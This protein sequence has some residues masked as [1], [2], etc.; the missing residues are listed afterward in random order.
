M[1]FLDGWEKAV[2]YAWNETKP[3]QFKDISTM[4]KVRL[5]IFFI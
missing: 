4:L 5:L 1:L 2:Q 3:E